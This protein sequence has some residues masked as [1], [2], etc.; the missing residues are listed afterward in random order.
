MIVE[1]KLQALGLRLPDLE[2]QYRANLS[3][4]RF[5][6]HYAVQNL[7]YLSGTTPMRDGQPFNTGVVGQDLTLEQGYEAARYAVLSS[8]AAVKYALE[9]LDRVEQIVQLIGFVNS[10]PGFGDQP[11]VI[12]GATDLLVELYGDRGKPTRAAIGCQGLA[13]N[14]SVEVV[15]TVLFTGTGVRPPLARD[16]FAR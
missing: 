16:Q 2:V 6:S 7:L 15:L 4:A 1:A 8:L 13:L 10:A 9:D 5:L 14:H 3:G 11:R 12:N